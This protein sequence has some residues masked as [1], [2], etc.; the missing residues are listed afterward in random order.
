VI[1]NF[2]DLFFIT[3]LNLL[4]LGFVYPW[5][6]A[7]IIIQLGK[8]RKVEILEIAFGDKVG[9]CLERLRQLKTFNT[10]FLE[11]RCANQLVK[12]ALPTIGAVD[13]FKWNELWRVWGEV[14]HVL[15][16]AALRVVHKFLL[17]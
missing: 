1:Q 10:R 17:I 5:K 11:R 12:L 16:V 9:C 4:T 15:F 13:G 3:C 2:L 14:Q 7:Y 8:G 6:K